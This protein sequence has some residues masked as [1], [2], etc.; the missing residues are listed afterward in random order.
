MILL[1]AISKSFDSVYAVKDLS[2]HVPEG[3][4]F[5]LLGPNGAGKTTTIK[6]MTGLQRPDAGRIVINGHD[7]V[8]EPEKAKAVTG[9]IPDKA[10]LYE[11]LT[12]REFL[13]F[14]ASLYGV[15]KGQAF[16]RIGDLLNLF[17]IPDVADDL[18]EG[19]SQGMK[20]R[21][22]FAASVIHN[23]R[24]LII[25]EPFVG[26]DP[27]GIRLIKDVLRDLGSQGTAIFLATHS[28]HLAGEL[29]HRIGFIRKG[30]LVAVRT[31]D[32]IMEAGGDLEELFM[33]LSGSEE[34]C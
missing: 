27:F 5:G 28:L 34:Q 22:I 26:L 16:P 12:G 25:D 13:I 23:P 21:L 2:L 30:M 11:K 14:I 6:M 20:Q 9:F 33:K 1:D 4:I 10:F 29:C 3:E 24:V 8:R 7:I 15:G 32:G 17:G 18:I 19:Y 31:R